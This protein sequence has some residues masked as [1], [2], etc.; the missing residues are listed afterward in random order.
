MFIGLVLSA[1]PGYS[2]TFFRN[3]ISMLSEAGVRVAVFVGRNREV[4]D[5][6]R[7]IEGFAWDGNIM[8]RA[9]ATIRLL[10]LLSGSPLRAAK[11]FRLNQEDGFS[12]RNNLLSLASSAHILK[13]SPDWLHFGFATVA[14]GRE[15]LAKVLGAK[16]AV[17]I[18]GYDIAVYPLKNKGCYNLLWK[19]LDKLHYIS[20]DLLALA[21]KHGF[22]LSRHHVKITPAIDT[23]LFTPAA[24]RSR[25]EPLRI[26]TIARLQWKKGLEYLLES[27]SILSERGIR[28]HCSIVGDGSEHE[29]LV[30]AGH[31]LSI[32]DHLSFFGVQNPSRV[33]ALLSETDLYVQYSIQEGFCNSVLEAQ[34]MGK[35]C[36]VSD[37]EGLA[38]NVVD[39]QTGWVVPRRD[40]ER[41]A[42]RICA[43]M[44]M[45][46]PE[47]RNVSKA[48]ID[49]VRSQ[50][51]LQRQKN[52]FLDF[53]T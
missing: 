38:E 50:F 41:L 7:F 43:V 48:A 19:R 36:V 51:S 15:N 23:S 27:L 22:D 13:F 8:V 24:D 28:F 34:A 37:A 42:D 25:D 29:R 3:K 10:L 14:V 9:M 40:P 4:E 44:N 52:A 35:L 47:L 45:T 2:E 20:D 33:K 18:R 32:S 12:V 21:T 53:Y 46:G 30:F 31:Q 49:R 6:D 11:L 39:G 16:M 1:T 26:L 17:S 5:R